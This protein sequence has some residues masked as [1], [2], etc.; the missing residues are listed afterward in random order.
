MVDPVSFH[1]RVSC[2]TWSVIFW[3]STLSPV[4]AS[5]RLPFMTTWSPAVNVAGE[6]LMER[7]AALAAIAEGIRQ[8]MAAMAS[9]ASSRGVC[10]REIIY[11]PP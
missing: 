8:K 11:M 1:E 9:I 2:D 4:T 6:V 10:V 5:V 7:T 3:R